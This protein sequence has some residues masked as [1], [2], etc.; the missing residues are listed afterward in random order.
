M[1]MERKISAHTQTSKKTKHRMIRFIE[2]LTYLNLAE[3]PKH[4]CLRQPAAVRGPHP[5]S[6]AQVAL[7]RLKQG[8]QA[9][10]V[11]KM[12]WTEW[13]GGGCFQVG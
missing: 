3:K 13:G 2:L 11:T 9:R 5:Y 4:Y 1:V 6:L 8:P 7:M 12:A 10:P